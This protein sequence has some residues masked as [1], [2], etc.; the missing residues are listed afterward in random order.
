MNEAAL[1]NGVPCVVF[2]V[3]VKHVAGYVELEEHVQI[4]Y[5]PGVVK[6][7]TCSSLCSN[8]SWFMRL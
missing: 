1:G 7:R 4:M 6:V 3:L 5:V 8:T 2:S